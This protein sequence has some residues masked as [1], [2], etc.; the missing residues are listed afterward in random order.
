MEY[1][2]IVSGCRATTLIEWR[3][4]LRT[5]MILRLSLFRCEV[6]IFYK[7]VPQIVGKEQRLGR[8]K[9]KL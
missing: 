4:E 9:P 5:G 6:N 2:G 1:V 8:Q 3:N 7:E